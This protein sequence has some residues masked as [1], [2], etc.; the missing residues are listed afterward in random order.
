[1]GRGETRVDVLV[2]PV[3]R[4]GE[5]MK[6]SITIYNDMGNQLNDSIIFEA[7]N[8]SEAREKLLEYIGTYT[9]QAGDTIKTKLV[10]S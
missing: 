1:M 4:R 7:K 3:L 9:F 2:L 8:E 5:N 6:F 10:E